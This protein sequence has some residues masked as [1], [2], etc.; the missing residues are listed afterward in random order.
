MEG[1]AQA[2]A[3][4]KTAAGH[5]TNQL[6]RYALPLQPRAAPELRGRGRTRTAVL[7]AEN[8]QGRHGPLPAPQR[9]APRRR[10]E[11]EAGRTAG[12]RR[13]EGKERPRGQSARGPAAEFGT[14][15]GPSTRGAPG[16]RTWR[17]GGARSG[18]RRP[19]SVPL[20]R[21]V[22]AAAAADRAG[23][24]KWRRRG[25][26]TDTAGGRIRAPARF[27]GPGR[28]SRPRVGAR[29][30]R[31][32]RERG[33]DGERAMQHRRWRDGKCRSHY[34]SWRKYP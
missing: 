1:R 18:Q 23:H 7:P 4:P 12:Q 11:F 17:S 20:T 28:L 13:R 25:R 31:V 32:R 5:S 22:P 33:G 21:P 14:H 8:G 3:A 2:P 26:S 9:K 19:E 24:S 6:Q 30:R 29:P 34:F 27:P 15:R 10:A 16:G